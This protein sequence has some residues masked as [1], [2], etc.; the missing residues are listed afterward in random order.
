MDKTLEIKKEEKKL[1]TIFKD[2]P[3]DKKSLCE[4][5]IKNAAFMYVT[6]EELQKEI[7]ENGAMIKYQS[8][9]GFHTIRDNPAQKAYT[10][11]IS[12]YTG[13]IDQ[14]NKMLPSD[15]IMQN[16]D[17]LLDFLKSN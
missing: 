3:E 11:M 6:L 14:L 10:T 16:N 1:N 7:N 17:E 8:G 9:N 12:R 2:I 4:G 13:I 5:L 15:K